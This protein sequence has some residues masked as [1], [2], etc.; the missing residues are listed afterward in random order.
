MRNEKTASG[1]S[2]KKTWGIEYEK[3]LSMSSSVCTLIRWIWVVGCMV[4]DEQSGM[5]V[6][7]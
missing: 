5:T 2:L 4:Q 1:E 6:N 3:W 7:R